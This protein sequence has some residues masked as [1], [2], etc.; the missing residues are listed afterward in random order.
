MYYYLKHKLRKII[1]MKTR[2]V[3]E[4]MN[5]LNLGK[6]IAQQKLLIKP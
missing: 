4:C 6:S 2:D 5:L 3:T 1:N